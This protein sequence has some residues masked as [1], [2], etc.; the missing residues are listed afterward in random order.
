M[1]TKQSYSTPLTEVSCFS[2][3]NRIL[4]NSNIQSF[5]EDFEFEEE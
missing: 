4:V 2:L 1:S 5:G 3:E